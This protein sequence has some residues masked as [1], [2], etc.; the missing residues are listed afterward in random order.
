MLYGEQGRYA[1]AEPLYKRA[2]A[3]SEK[4]LGP[5]HPDVASSLNNLAMLYGSKAATPRPSLCPNAPSPSARRRS[6]PSTQM[7]PPVSTISRCSTLSK[8]AMPRPSLCTQRALAIG[9]KAL[10]P[11]HPEVGT[12]L[13]N[14]AMLYRAQRRYAEAEPLQKRALAISEKALGPEHPAVGTSLNNLALLYKA[15]GRYAEAEPLQKRALAI[16]EKALGIDHPKT[17]AIRRDLQTLRQSTA[18]TTDVHDG[19]SDAGDR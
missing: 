18:L 10:G 19:Q 9:E 11:E 6:A 8:A 4:A 12:R 14:L 16:R 13:N 15:Q 5:E 17:V 7:S 2:L 3:I 1:E